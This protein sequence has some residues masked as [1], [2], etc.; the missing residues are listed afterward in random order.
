MRRPASRTASLSS[1]TRSRPGPTSTLFQG[2]PRDADASAFAPFGV[3][4]EPPAEFGGRAR[5]DEWLMPVT[6]RTP[7]YHLNR[8]SPTTLPVTVDRVERGGRR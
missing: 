3:F 6:G 4:L 1:P 2:W 8:V 7:H 5:F